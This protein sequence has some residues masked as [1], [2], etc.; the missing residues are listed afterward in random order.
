MS[1]VRRLVVNTGMQALVVIIIKIVGDADLGV[2]QVGKHGSFA[3]FKHLRFEAGPQA[4]GWGITVAVAAAALRAYR[5][6]V[7]ARGPV[8]IAAVLAAAVG[9]DQRTRRERL[10]PKSAL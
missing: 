2:S 6:V 5:P 9:V 3:Q 1:A 7:V 10:G 8:G 4:F